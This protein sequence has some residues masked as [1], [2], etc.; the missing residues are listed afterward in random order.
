MQVMATASIPLSSLVLGAGGGGGGG[1][2]PQVLSGS[3][4]LR[5]ATAGVAA[6][7]RVELGRVQAQVAWLGLRHRVDEE[8]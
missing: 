2:A 7:D 6:P 4:R 3:W 1:C 5:E 8:E